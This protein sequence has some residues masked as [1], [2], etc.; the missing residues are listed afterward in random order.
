MGNI[1][2]KYKFDAD[3]FIEEDLEETEGAI[4]DYKIIE[5]EMSTEEFNNLQEWDG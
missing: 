2:F 5:G 4:K 1:I 3:L